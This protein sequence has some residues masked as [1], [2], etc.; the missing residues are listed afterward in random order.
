[1]FTIYRI[2]RNVYSPLDPTGAIITPGR[3]HLPGQSV[4]YFSSSLAMCILE[5]KANSVSFQTIR[6]GFHFIKSEIYSDDLKVSEVPESFYTK[7]WIKEKTLSQ[8]YGNKWFRLKKSPLLKIKSS[9]LST[10]YNFIINTSHPD[11]SKLKFS[12]PQKIPLDVKLK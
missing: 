2:C 4:L 5:L 8:K 6:E 1:L 10:D 3:W 9:V 12:E 11:F 7:N